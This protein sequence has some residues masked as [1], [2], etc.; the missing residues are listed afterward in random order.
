VK[1]IA[2]AGAAVLVVAIGVVAIVTVGRDEGGRSELTA[3]ERHGRALFNSGGCQ[4]CH[5]LGATHAGGQVG[6]NLDTWAPWGIPPGVVAS[7][8]R[9]GRSSVYSNATMPA[10]LLQG[11]DVD[12][13]AAF[14]HRVTRDVARRRGGPPPLDWTPTVPQTRP[15]VPPAPAQT[16]PRSP[17]ERTTTNAPVERR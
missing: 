3:Q 8:V 9:E 2:L 12:D 11:G 16:P 1:A 6:P 15:R 17:Q 13:V 5:T 10:G 14:V 4:R 7:A